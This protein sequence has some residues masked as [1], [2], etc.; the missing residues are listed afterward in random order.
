VFASDVKDRWANRWIGWRGYAPFFASTARA[1]ARARRPLLDLRVAQR[2][3][4]AGR[5]ILTVAL[6]ARDVHGGYRDLERP[7]L[8]VRAGS[9]QSGEVVMH[10]RG[11][12]RYETTVTAAAT[13]A[14]SLAVGDAGSRER[15]ERLVVPD[16][17]AEYR[18]RPP[19]HD[20]LRG[21]AEATG[22]V[23]EPSAADLM[24]GAERRPARRDLWPWL[25]AIAVGI[26]FADIL[27][28]RIR[29]A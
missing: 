29:L 3:V 19:D 15:T 2:D 1:L 4:A 12:G 8:S 25:V 13:E 23:Y 22:G 26:W 21:I 7:T 14:L 27:L 20:R 10:Q 18:L 24:A 6:E 16:E 17:A 9:G 28:R 11:P 5:Q